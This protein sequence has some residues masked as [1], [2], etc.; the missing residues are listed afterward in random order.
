MGRTAQNTWAN[1]AGKGEEGKHGGLSRPTTSERASERGRE[2]RRGG[3]FTRGDAGAAG[4]GGGAAGA[5]GALRGEAHRALRRGGRRQGGGRRRRPRGL[6]ARHGRPDHRRRAPEGQ[7]P[8]APAR[9]AA[10][11]VLPVRSVRKNYLLRGGL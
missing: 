7:E 6:R 9:R 10:L 8:L 2:R 11:P 4:G 3:K 5:A 1:W